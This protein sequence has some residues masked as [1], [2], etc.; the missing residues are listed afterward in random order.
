M[1]KEN[2]SAKTGNQLMAFKVTILFKI[3]LQIRVKQKTQLPFWKVIM[4]NWV[5]KLSKW[6][7][8]LKLLMR[9]FMLHIALQTCKNAHTTCIPCAFTME[10][11]QVGIITRLFMTDSLKNGESLAISESLT[12]AKK[13]SS[14]KQKVAMAGLQHIGLSTC[15]IAFLKYYKKRISTT[16]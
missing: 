3:K 14:R 6:R 10:M 2:I 13:T 1:S 8:K 7:I 15:T 12:T 4:L 5:N 11:P 9:K 16:T